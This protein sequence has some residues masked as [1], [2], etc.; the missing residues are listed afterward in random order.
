MRNNGDRTGGAAAADVR[1]ASDARS[2][3]HVQVGL[4]AADVEGPRQMEPD[5][6]QFRQGRPHEESQE[7]ADGGKIATGCYYRLPSVADGL[8]ISRR[9]GWHFAKD[10]DCVVVVI[11]RRYFCNLQHAFFQGEMSKRLAL[12]LL[13][14]VS[15]PS[16]MFADLEADEDGAVPNVPQRIA[17]RHT[18]RPRP[19]SPISQLDSDGKPVYGR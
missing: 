2:L 17:S 8:S 15:N 9:G 5:V 7:K 3:P 10:A 11:C 1:F 16:H 13:Q 18:A 6:S 14:K 4:Q 12:E 19:K